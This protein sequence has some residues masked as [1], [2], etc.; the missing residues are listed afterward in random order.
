[1][2]ER[3]Q[4]LILLTVLAVGLFGWTV[5]NG[6]YDA[7]AVKP[8]KTYCYEIGVNALKCFGDKKDCKDE[9]KS[10]PNALSKCKAR[11]AD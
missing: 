11:A 6:S 10:D 4:S 8:V 7:A 3:K 2:M 1:M 9:Q 5:T